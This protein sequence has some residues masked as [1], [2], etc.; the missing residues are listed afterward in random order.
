MK[1][2]SYIEKFIFKDFRQVFAEQKKMKT[3]TA[4]LFLTAFSFLVR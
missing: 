4:L 3:F 1:V 2:I